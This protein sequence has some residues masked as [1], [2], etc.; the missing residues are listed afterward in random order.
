MTNPDSD[1]ELA[2]D[3]LTR[4]SRE[5]ERIVIGQ[6]RVIKELLCAQFAE[7]HA[8]LEG[9]PGQG[10]TLL[11]RSLAACL[12]LEL[13]RIQCTPDLLPA[14]I[15]GSE[16]L[17]GNRELAFRPGPLFAPILLVDEINRAT[18]RTQ[19]AFLEA[20]QERQVT[21]LGQ[22]HALPSPF[23]LLATQNPI[24]LEGTYPLPEAQLDRFAM[25]IDVPFIQRETLGQL[26]DMTLD[27]PTMP[28]ANRI[29]GLDVDL[30]LR[31]VKRIVVADA[32][33]DMAVTLI[34]ELQPGDRGR[35]SHIRYG[36]S[37]RA[38]QSLLRCAQSSALLNGRAHVSVA[39]LRAV[40]MPVLRHRLLLEFESELGGLSADEIVR[41]TVDERLS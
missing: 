25:K 2:H 6:Q 21:W 3:A 33:R 17:N 30:I 5:L 19:S 28:E 1:F 38:L 40:A 39:D 20:M 9:L 14:D 31:E 18:P 29:D 27:A 24:E 23:W 26:A 8:L 37:P 10:K 13:S 41:A 36:P 12:D 11:A 34:L 35:R 15:T 32:L 7:G 22:R 16:V 4:L